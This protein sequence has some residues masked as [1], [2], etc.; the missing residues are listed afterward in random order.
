MQ[1]TVQMYG[2]KQCD[3]VY[4]PCHTDGTYL[5]FLELGNTTGVERTY[6]PPSLDDSSATI[7]IPGGFPFGGSLQPLVYVRM[8][9]MKY[10][11][12]LK[13]CDM[14]SSYV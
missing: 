4:T 9:L 2:D 11:P 14:N 12:R 7:P 8:Y 6:L 1:S 3:T 5:P 10:S 13:M